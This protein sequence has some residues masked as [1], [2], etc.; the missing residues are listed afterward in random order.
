[1]IVEINEMNCIYFTSS[2]NNLNCSIQLGFYLAGLIQGD[3]NTWSP[4]TLK[5]P[6]GRI[7][8]PQITFTLHINPF[9]VN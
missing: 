9:S 1:M 2:A 5:P 7:N 8:N 6:K 3:G 4:K